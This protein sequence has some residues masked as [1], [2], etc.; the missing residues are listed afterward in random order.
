MKKIFFLSGMLITTVSFSQT[1]P[2]GGGG[3]LPDPGTPVCGIYFDYDNAGNR[4]KRYY[5][6]KAF[7]PTDPGTLP[8]DL[9]PVTGGKQAPGATTKAGQLQDDLV[10]VYPNPA[11]TY[12]DITF[13]AS[14]EHAHYHL[15]DIK[16]SLLGSGYIDGKTQRVPLSE[17]PDGTYM[18]AV[19]NEGRRYQFKITVR[20]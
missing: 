12:V 2:G 4:I 14:V 3:T 10:R 7:E 11:Q 20:H 18:V 15:Y 9:P 13:S 19:K 5:D 1:L 16:G 8:G 6:C 17:Y